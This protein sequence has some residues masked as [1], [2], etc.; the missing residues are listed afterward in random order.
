M[1]LQRLAPTLEG[2]SLSKTMHNANP[3]MTA[4]ARSGLKIRR[5]DFD[6]MLAAHV[7][8]KK[9]LTLQALALESLSQELPPITDLLGTGRRRVTM[10]QVPIERAAA[11]AGAE[12][13]YTLRL[14]AHT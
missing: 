1:A 3:G 7:S 8:G 12:A 14:R 9:A 2:Q 10:A 13:D 5:V 11:H 6:T 4:L